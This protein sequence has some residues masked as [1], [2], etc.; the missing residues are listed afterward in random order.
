MSSKSISSTINPPTAAIA[1][2]PDGYGRGDARCGAFTRLQSLLLQKGQATDD[3][4][5]SVAGLKD[6]ETLAIWDGEKLSDAGVK[7]L[8]GLT[9]LKNID[10]DHRAMGDESLKVFGQ[11]PALSR[12]VLQQNDFTDAGL[13]HLAKSKQLQSLWLG[14]NRPPSPTRAFSIWPV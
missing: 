2:R 7:H 1:Q 8:A 4:L 13:E 9:K 6:L 5:R 10:I 11:M 3:G 12:L 14:M